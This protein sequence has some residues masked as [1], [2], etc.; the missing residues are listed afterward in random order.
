VVQVTYAYKPAYELDYIVVTYN[1]DTSSG[2]VS[3]VAA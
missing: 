2:T 1:V 3:P